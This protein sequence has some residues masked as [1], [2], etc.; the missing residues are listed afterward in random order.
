[1]ICSDGG[2]NESTV[3]PL[4]TSY[5]VRLLG[6]FGLEHARGEHIKR[7]TRVSNP[8]KLIAYL[9][10]QPPSSATKSMLGQQIWNIEE[11][12]MEQGH[13]SPYD[14]GSPAYLVGPII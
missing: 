5:Y 8:I 9:A 3:S 14:T 2:N 6:G 1:M 10:V 13:T 7:T 11:K 12:D 4:T